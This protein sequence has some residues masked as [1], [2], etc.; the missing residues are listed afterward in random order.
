ML[1]PD[2]VFHL[3]QINKII[4]EI[5]RRIFFLKELQLLRL[6]RYRIRQTIAHSTRLDEWTSGKLKK[7]SKNF[8]LRI[9][10]K[11]LKNRGKNTFLLT[12][13][14]PN[15]GVVPNLT[16]FWRF[17]FKNVQAENF[18]RIFLGF[19]RGL[20]IKARRLSYRLSNSVVWELQKFTFIQQQKKTRQKIL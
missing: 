18:L 8:Q 15:F 19:S 4:L 2:C 14:L 13:K 1:S 20:P 5:S 3:F 7:N 11:N 9:F 17:F 16:L 10:S 12:Y 6:P